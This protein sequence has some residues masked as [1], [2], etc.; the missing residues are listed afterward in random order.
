MPI[1]RAEFLVQ[2]SRYNSEPQCPRP[3]ALFESYSPSYSVAI[4][5]TLSYGNQFHRDYVSVVQFV[6][7]GYGKVGF[8]RDKDTPIHRYV[9]DANLTL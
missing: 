4:I 5:S 7:G 2:I 1:Y 8:L 6:A 3:R 9:D